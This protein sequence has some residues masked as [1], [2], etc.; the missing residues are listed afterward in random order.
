MILG[1]CKCCLHNRVTCFLL[2]LILLASSAS[3]P[4]P[5]EPAKLT[6]FSCLQ[7]WQV[8]S[9]TPLKPRANLLTSMQSVWQVSDN[10]FLLLLRLLHSVLDT[11][12][13]A[14]SCAA[15]SLLCMGVQ[16][17]A[18]TAIDVCRMTSTWHV[19]LLCSSQSTGC[20][21]AE[22]ARTQEP[23]STCH[24][25][26]MLGHTKQLGREYGGLPCLAGMSCHFKMSTLP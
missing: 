20:I 21:Q 2:K 9:P 22:Q 17:A 11:N 1:A 8:T 6:V 26:L 13:P 12:C 18:S 24:C 23:E 19:S 14:H 5:A 3:F 10:P 4:A 15:L 7:S 16:T 25:W